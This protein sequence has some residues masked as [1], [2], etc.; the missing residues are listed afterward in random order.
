M[1]SSHF[2]LRD[3]PSSR[4][5]VAPPSKDVSDILEGLTAAPEDPSGAAFL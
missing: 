1:E 5:T 4:S 2:G 3:A